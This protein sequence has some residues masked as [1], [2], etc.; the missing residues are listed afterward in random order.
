MLH[1]DKDLFERVVL[2][3]SEKYGIVPV[4]IEKDYY[5][6]LFL[7]EIVKRQPKIIFKGGTSLSKCYHL[8]NRFSEDIDL[9]IESE[10]KPTEGQRRNL[11]GAVR[12]IVADYGFVLKNP[13]DIRSRRDFNKYIIDYP[14]KLS[15]SFLKPDIIVE[16]AVF[17]RAYPS[18]PMKADSLVYQYLKKSGY[19]DL[20]DQ[21]EL[22][23][24]DVNVQTADRTMI[25]KLFALGDYYLSG[26]IDEHSRHI[27]DLHK[28]YEVVEINDNL[29]QLAEQVRAERE[30]H[31][32][33]LSAKADVNMNE[34]LQEII[35]TNVYKAD[36]ESKTYNMLY[37][38]VSYEEA[39]ETLKKIIEKKMF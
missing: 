18:K 11:V 38:K 10:Q 21:Y 5:V 12:D 32:T 14:S 28:L 20:I 17:F 34:L 16:T 25:D 35:D 2:D 13:D 30:P 37:K 33:C 1:N 36:Y 3:I 7:R 23:P 29:R 6:S 27:Y 8:I 22:E 15:V 4:I 19:D 24:F 26:T 31:K 9:N 39:V